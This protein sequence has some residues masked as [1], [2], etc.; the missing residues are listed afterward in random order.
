MA[1]VS[2]SHLDALL[3]LLSEVR[4]RLGQLVNAAEF[5][6]DSVAAAG[7]LAAPAQG[8]LLAQI[9]SNR[10]PPGVYEVQVIAYN[11]SA[12]IGDLANISL[13]RGSQQITPLFSGNSS[14]G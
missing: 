2:S 13:N 3:G 11:S 8:A 1:E 5:R 12:V 10:L 9:P 4:D 7:A 6:E 14:A